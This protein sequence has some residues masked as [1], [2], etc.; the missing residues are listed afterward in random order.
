M[1]YRSHVFIARMGDFEVA[2]R[3]QLSDKNNPGQLCE[4]AFHHEQ[5]KFYDHSPSNDESDDSILVTVVS[6]MVYSLQQSLS[7]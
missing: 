7:R 3:D 2:W 1:S 4:I 6:N 5:N